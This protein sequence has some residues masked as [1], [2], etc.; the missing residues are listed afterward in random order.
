MNLRE[1][2]KVSL[3]HQIFRNSAPAGVSITEHEHSPPLDG[4]CD[5][6]SVGRIQAEIKWSDIKEKLNH[7]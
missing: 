1:N 7:I 6:K 4:E 3:I 2:L 5:N